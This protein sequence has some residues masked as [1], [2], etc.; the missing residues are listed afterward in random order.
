VRTKSSLAPLAALAAALFVAAQWSAPSFVPLQQQAALRGC[1]QAPVAEMAP[2]DGQ[3]GG[4]GHRRQARACGDP[5]V[6]PHGDRQVPPLGYRESWFMKE[7]SRWCTGA[8]DKRRKAEAGARQVA[9]GEVQG[10]DGST[11]WGRAGCCRGETTAHSNWSKRTLRGGS[12]LCSVRAVL[13]RRFRSGC[14]SRNPR[15]PTS[16]SSDLEDPA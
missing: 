1:E 7:R 16:S 14:R 2:V 12:A 8:G 5:P 15:E 9:D 13:E 10:S 11:A 3:P 4:G 6:E